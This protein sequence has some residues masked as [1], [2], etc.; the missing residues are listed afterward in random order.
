MYMYFFCFVKSSSHKL[1]YSQIN[2]MYIDLIVIV[3]ETLIYASF[4]S[5][6]L[7]WHHMQHLS[8]WVQFICTGMA[9]TRHIIDF[10]VTYRAISTTSKVPKLATN[11]LSL[12]PTQRKLW[13]KRYTIVSQTPNT[14]YVHAIWKKTWDVNY[15]TEQFS[16]LNWTN[17]SCESM[18]R[19]S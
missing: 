18:S 9:T 11:N 16:T 10:S 5:N 6:V 2:I 1:I 13:Q 3:H 12:V 19:I 17:N 8:W 14:Y 15:T 7:L 4:I